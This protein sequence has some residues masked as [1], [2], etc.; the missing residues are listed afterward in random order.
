LIPAL[1]ATLAELGADDRAVAAIALARLLVPL[2]ILRVPLAIVAALA[3]DAA[4][5]SLLERFSDVD[6]GPDGPYQ[7]FDKAL[8]IYYLAIAY[9]ATMRN[10]TSDAAFRIGRFLFYY[11]LV[12]VFLFEV[13]DSRAMLFVF[14]NTFEYFF[15]AY[16]LV[17]LSY[18][19]SRRP[20]GFW[21]ATGVNLWVVVKLPQEYWTHIEQGDFTDS[22]AD[23]PVI[24]LVCALIVV[25]LAAVLVLV[26]RPRLPDPD[27]RWRFA[28]D[29][30]DYESADAHAGH[31]QRLRR[32]EVLWGEL[33]EKALL[34][35]L[36]AVIFASILPGV[37]ATWLE[38]AAAAAAVVCANT[39]ISIAYARSERLTLESAVAELASLLAV[40]VGLVYIASRLIGDRDDFP[41]GEG[42]FFACLGTL[43]LWLYDTYKPLA[44]LRFAGSER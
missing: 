6:L 31:A 22:A 15:I 41:V 36:L 4:D 28:A 32:R 13:L 34:L 7:S 39:A 44:D 9:L 30:P 23:H 27:W 25:S 3:L 20:A 17:R 26:V 11:R 29:H 33:A 12:G 43:I 35:G 40:N 21:L 38:V 14:P 37:T 2:L 16:E 18:E 5:N 19:P 42:L 8:D 10:W 24:Y 1:A